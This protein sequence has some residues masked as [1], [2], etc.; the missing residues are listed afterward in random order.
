[1]ALKPLKRL[2]S[3]A[4]AN[5]AETAIGIYYSSLRD[6][7]EMANYG[8][9]TTWL[10]GFNNSIQEFIQFPKDEY[11]AG[12]IS[13]AVRNKNEAFEAM[14]DICES[15]VRRVINKYGK[16]SA[17]Y[18]TFGFE[19]YGRMDEA[20]KIQTAWSVHKSGTDLLIA[21]SDQG[22]TQSILDN[23]TTAI[24][25]A[26]T[27]KVAK[28]ASVKMRD[29]KVQERITKGNAVYTDM[30]K[31]ADTG[32][33]IWEDTDETKYNDYVLYSG[34]SDSTQTVEITVAATEIVQPSV[35]IE[36]ADDRIR[37]TNSG[38]AP[39]KIYF[40]TD[41]SAEPPVNA[42]F[43]SPGTNIDTT[44]ADQGWTEINHRL[45]VKNESEA[46]QTEVIVR[47]G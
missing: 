2:Y 30:V 8:F 19:G 41:P 1:M 20:H 47:V 27:G 32:K 25:D 11:Y 33:E 40:A 12:Q 26:Q 6:A 45:L 18:R 5:M 35:E 36:H 3:I 37:I 22:L 10:S 23:L 16:N 34:I 28:E 46:Q 24:S 39:V 31:L 13:I 15:I 43:L 14:T 44:A 7:T 4:D 9:T 21:L 42:T 17:E 29:A 38:P